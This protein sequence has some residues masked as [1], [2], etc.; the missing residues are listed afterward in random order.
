MRA[1]ASGL[2]PSERPVGLYVSIYGDAL[3]GGTDG[4]SYH[5]VL[6]AA[7][8]RDAASGRYDGWPR[9][10]PEALLALDPELIVTHGGMMHALCSRSGL[11]QLR[12][13]QQRRVVEVDGAL[14]GD[15]GLSML[16][17]AEDV[18]DAIH[19]Q[20]SGAKLAHPSTK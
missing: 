4:T 16:D 1:V 11:D 19:R 14:L 6:T 15:P 5:D 2:P 7:G 18:F 8:V 12:A 3:Y 13:C 10:T 20:G 9:Y 17:A